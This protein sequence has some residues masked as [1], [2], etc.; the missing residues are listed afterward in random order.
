MARRH[1]TAVVVL[2]HTAFHGP[3]ACKM[4]ASVIR[5]KCN[6]CCLLF[7]LFLYICQCSL[8]TEARVGLVFAIEWKRG[9]MIMFTN[10]VKC[11]NKH[12]MA[13]F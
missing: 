7:V 8:L 12:Y 3:V 10:D 2:V 4:L 6:L 1:H 11:Y 9:I 5:L 13:V